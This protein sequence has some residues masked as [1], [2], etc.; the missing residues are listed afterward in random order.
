MFKKLLR[1]LGENFAALAL[2]VGVISTSQACHFF[3]NQ[4]K[5]PEE[6]REVVRKRQK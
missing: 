3:L 5:V 4:K 6:M 1:K 2:V